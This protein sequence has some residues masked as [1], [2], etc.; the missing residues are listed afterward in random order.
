MEM[1]ERLSRLEKVRDFLE[2]ME[3]RYTEDWR[4]R[5]IERIDEGIE[6]LKSKYVNEA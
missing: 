3:V 1:G 2:K 5:E 6:M 4:R